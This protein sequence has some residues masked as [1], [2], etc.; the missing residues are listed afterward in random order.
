MAFSNVD[1]SDSQKYAPPPYEE[2]PRQRC[3]FF[4]GCIIASILSLLLLIAV[5]VVLFVFYRFLGQMIE[6]YA[7][8]APRELPKIEMPAEQFRTLKERVE[9]FSA[10]VKEG[11][12]TEPLALTSDEI[13]ALIEERPSLKGKFYVTIEKDR[14]KG[15][16]SFPLTDIANIGI[17]RGRYLN[18]EAEFNVWLKDGV[19][20]VTIASFEINGKRPS[21]QFLQSIRSQNLAKDAD[22]DPKSAEVIRN[23]ESIEI[24]AGR[25]IIKARDRTDARAADN[26][27]ESPGTE[28]QKKTIVHPPEK[29]P[30]PAGASSPSAEKLPDDV[31][32]PADPQPATRAEPA[33]RP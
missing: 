10:A 30:G 32:A 23:L 11:K 22:T 19:L 3:C 17:T 7:A 26:S 20:F 29:P 6:E 18:G 31:L 12:P 8:T 16:V 27:G 1:F 2:P 33:N 28:T 13:N 5:G 4:Y 24:D 14:L 25:L 21:E 9:A 15:Q